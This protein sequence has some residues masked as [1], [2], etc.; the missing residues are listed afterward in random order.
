MR[1]VTGNA[2]SRLGEVLNTHFSVQR[3]EVLQDDTSDN[4]MDSSS[5]AESDSE[6]DIVISHLRSSDSSESESDSKGIQR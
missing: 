3:H 6:D 2:L 4:D 1:R 5:H